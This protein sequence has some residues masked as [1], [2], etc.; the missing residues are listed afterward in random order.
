LF[1]S[2]VRFLRSPSE[3]YGTW[4]QYSPIDKPEDKPFQEDI[5]FFKVSDLNKD[6]VI[7]NKI[8]EQKPAWLDTQKD[9]ESYLRQK[10]LI[11]LYEK[12]TYKI[13]NPKSALSLTIINS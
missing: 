9:K 8:L 6:D 10:A 4:N 3:P 13:N 12:F 7:R 1:R 5:F 2:T 11:N